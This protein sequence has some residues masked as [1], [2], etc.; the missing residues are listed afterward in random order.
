[1]NC[2]YG[3]QIKANAKAPNLKE[4]PFVPSNITNDYGVI[5]GD[6]PLKT[7]H[8]NHKLGKTMWC[9]NDRTENFDIIFDL[10]G[11]YPVGEIHIWNYN[12]KEDEEPYTLC[13]LRE[14]TL[15]YSL[16]EMNWEQAKKQPI[17]L[18]KANGE[19]NMPP[20]N[21]ENGQP[22][23]FGG[24]T[25][26]Y[27]KIAV[28]TTP[29][30]GNYDADNKF[31]NSYGISK[32]RF[33]A[34]EGF[35]I[36]RDEE[37]CSILN[38]TKGWTGSDG[39]FTIPMNGNENHCEDVDTTITFGDSLIDDLE[40]NTF[41]R[42]SKFHM[43][44][45]SSCFIQ[46]SKPCRKNI[47]FEWGTDDKG[48]D[49]SLLNPPL[50][51]Q[52]DKTTSGYYWPQ[53]SVLINDKCYTYPLTVLDW[54]EGPE[55]FKFRVDGV[56][57]VIS[58]KENGRIQW[59]KATHHK[60]NLYYERPEKSV[61]YGGCVFNNTEEAG[62]KHP[63]GYVYLLGTIHE[64]FDT[65]LCI[66]R[67]L[68]ENI[69]DGMSWT[70]FDG[71]NWTDDISKSAPLADDVSCELSLSYVHGK[72]H[73]GKY[74]LIYQHKVNSPYIAYRTAPTPW[75]PYSK[76]N[77]VYFTDD[78]L[79]GRGIYTYNAKAHPHLAKPGE[80]LISYNTNTV[81]WEMHEAHGDICRPKFLRM[82]EVIKDEK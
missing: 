69:D 56:A 10:G 70:F 73:H 53:D 40:P 5:E 4:A 32:V 2:K 13:G 63:D 39:V 74:I 24:R 58:P 44:H 19:S 3:D 47:E 11:Y 20:S 25:I 51:V 49:T 57:M 31:N 82:R 67:T 37:W 41:K 45:N 33:Y 77:I 21:L 71:E 27:I 52:N 68:V 43:I 29:G 22:F 28:N 61:F 17:I 80:F 8:D 60:T 16:D 81:T 64:G 65:S 59:T 66:A 79:N 55:G 1:M 9:I 36:S 76:A 48:E 35:E 12:R 62:A 34:G 7:L 42:S 78:V 38:Q 46:S 14:I 15:Y 6:T 30:V 50:S 75:G 23:D 54:P 72:L 26:R 18:A